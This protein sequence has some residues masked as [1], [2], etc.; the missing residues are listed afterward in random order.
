MSEQ[1][2]LHRRPR[3]VGAILAGFGVFVLIAVI[4]SLSLDDGS[5]RQIEI[6]GAGSTQK[7]MGGIQQ[8]GQFLGDSDSEVTVEVFNDV[9]C[10]RCAEWQQDTINPLIE[11]YV[12]DGDVKL[13]FRHFSLGDRNTQVGA[14]AATSAGIQDRQ[15]QYIEI[16]MAN[17]DELKAGVVSEDYL[18]GVANA[19]LE[20]DFEKWKEDFD[21]PSVAKTVEADGDLATERRFPG[22]PAVVVTGPLRSRELIESPSQEEIVAAIDAVS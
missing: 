18:A 10:E 1:Q 17:L 21:D 14:Y 7:L 3:L 16:F 8:E 19:V 15:W 11:P 22:E 12:R 13:Q 2:P 6:S 4:A 5:D 9:Q 20:L